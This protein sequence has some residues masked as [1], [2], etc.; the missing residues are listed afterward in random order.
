MI[1]DRKL[2][3]E[4]KSTHELHKSANRQIYNYLRSTNLEV[5]LLLH[6]GPDARFYRVVHRNQKPNPSNPENP[7]HPDETSV[8]VA[9]Y[10]QAVTN[11]ETAGGPEPPFSDSS[12]LKKT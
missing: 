11:V 7:L 6:F 10:P 2:V 5:G 12:C 3:V 8:S 1:V 9:G 4:T